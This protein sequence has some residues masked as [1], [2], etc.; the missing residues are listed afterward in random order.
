VRMASFAGIGRNVD[1]G[2]GIVE[3]WLSCFLEQVY[4]VCER[5]QAVAAFSTGYMGFE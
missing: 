1:F 2:I 5:R 3:S 4:Y